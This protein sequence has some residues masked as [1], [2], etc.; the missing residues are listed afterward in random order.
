MKPVDIKSKAYINFN[1]EYN[2]KDPKLKVGD[3]VRIS[4]YE[5]IFAKCYVP[6][7]SQEVFVIKK[8]KIFCRENI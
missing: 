4:K 6:N 7:W 5:N 2:Y 8:V 3:Y 1:K